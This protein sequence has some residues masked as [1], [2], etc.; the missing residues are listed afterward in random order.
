MERVVS[1]LGLGVFLAIAWAASTDRKAIRWKLVAW[2][3]GLQVLFGLLILKTPLGESVFDALSRGIT[4]L[5]GFTDAGAGFVWGWLYHKD[6]SNPV[7]L[8]DILMVI[9]FF[10]ALMSLLY[11]LGLMQKVIEGVA[12]VMRRTMGTSGS[13]TLSAAAN[14]FVG[15]TEAP[16]VVKPFLETM[17][18]SELHAVMVGGF[19]TIAGS[20]LGA[21][22]SFG[23]DAGHLV[24]ASF[25][26]APAALVAAKMFMPETEASVTAGHVALKLEKTTANVF[27]AVC[28]GASDGLK[29]VFNV[30]AMLLAFVAIIAMLNG[31]IEYVVPGLTLQKMAGWLLAPVA[32]IMGVPWSDCPEIGRLLGTRMVLT[33]FKAYLDLMEMKDISA[34]SYVIAVYAFCGFANFPSIAVQIGGISALAPG[35]RSDLARLGLRAMLAG[36]LASFF[37]AG[38]AGALLSDEQVERD[39]RRNRARVAKTA[40]ER[41]A[42]CDAFLSKF[43]ASPYA[44]AFRTLRESK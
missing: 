6:M 38:I 5:I 4:R 30:F 8:I 20:V 12:W 28:V 43:P 17:T 2:G 3:M 44:P 9:V 19:A 39:F 32:W 15:Q 13:E 23:I 34:R 37:T 22:I 14:I 21:Y 31:G 41:R 33:E 27:D 35:R 11:H 25:M 18:K 7:F 36:T 42:E 26:S 16:L 10:S 40:E 24:A 1:F 29:L